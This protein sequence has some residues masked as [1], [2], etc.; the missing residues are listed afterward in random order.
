MLSTTGCDR[1]PL[2]I[3]VRRP[4]MRLRGSSLTDATVDGRS[5]GVTGQHVWCSKHTTNGSVLQKRSRKVVATIVPICTKVASMNG[6]D[7]SS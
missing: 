1:T 7:L 3:A 2:S 5:S 4:T 6:G